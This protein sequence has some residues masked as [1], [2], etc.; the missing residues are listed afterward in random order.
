MPSSTPTLSPTAGEFCRLTV[1]QPGG[2]CDVAVPIGT[3]VCSLLPVLLERL[4]Q[5]PQERGIPWVLQRLG[6]DPL[7]PDGTPETLGLRHGDVLHLRPADAPLPSLHFDDVAD[8]VAHVISG[9]PDRWRPQTT[10]QLA[11]ALSALAL[12][13]LAAALVG[14]GPG[15]LTAASAAMIAAV[16]TGGCVLA[17]H[18]GADRGAVVLAGLGALANGALT[19]LLLRP[20]P[21]GGFALVAVCV[22][23]ASGCMVAISVVLLVWRL[24]PFVIPGT[25]L[26]TGLA[27]AGC[28]ELVQ[29]AHWHGDQ[30]VAVVA[31]VLFLLGHAGPRLALRAAGLR[32]PLLPHNAEELQ[33]DI[34][35]DPLEKVEQTVTA[36]NAYLNSLCLASAL[37]CTAAFWCL[38]QEA[39]WI[40]WLLPLVFS[41]AVLLRSRGLTGTLQRFPMVLA[42]AVGLAL[43]LLVR[44][45]PG[46][47]GELAAVLAVLL[48][49]AVLLILFAQRLNSR[50]L[51]VWGHSGDILELAS[52]IAL[53]PLLLQA[54]HT[55]AYF[56][57][58]AG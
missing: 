6:E 41:A 29:V 12:V 7:D 45:A 14:A 57:S 2:R 9:R 54:T 40:G 46:G 10:R 1:V 19:G 5:T 18:T 35:P 20:G 33:Q 26:L 42:G 3:P 44:V 11:L 56:R 17:G 48:A 31:V 49:A 39:G 34:T 4:Q 43:V 8:G 28:A 13:A 30:A 16:L 55:Y 51:P 25:A 50:L 23:N 22:L 47:A 21:H 15:V 53:L 36:A 24:L 38:T 27:A 58:L 52:A 37:V 32:V